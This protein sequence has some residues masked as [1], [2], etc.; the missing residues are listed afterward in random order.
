MDVTNKQFDE[1]V[2][3]CREIFAKKLHDYGAS[4]RILR[5]ESV[6]DQIFIKANRIRSLEVKKENKVN[7]GIFPEFIGIV[8]YGIIALIQLQ[9]GY[10]DSIDLSPEKALE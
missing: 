8:N 5:P 7:E 10:A 1:V 9:L 2:L 4:W 3:I 6:T